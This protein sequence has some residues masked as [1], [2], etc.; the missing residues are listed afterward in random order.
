MIKQRNKT[1]Q[2]I[3]PSTKTL[4]ASDGIDRNEQRETEQISTLSYQPWLDREGRTDYLIGTGCGQNVNV[5]Q[6]A[7]ERV[8]LAL[9]I[10]T[11][12]YEPNAA[13]SVTQEEIDGLESYLG[14]EAAG[15]SL[16]EIACLVIQ[17]EIRRQH[18]RLGDTPAARSMDWSD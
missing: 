5:D 8:L 17:R 18:N 4:N 11:S 12:G 16:D 14:D 7:T 15:R 1:D 9:K 6:S 2:P 10:L 3:N 13:N